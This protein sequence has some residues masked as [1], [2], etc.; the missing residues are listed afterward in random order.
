V[1]ARVHVW[2]ARTIAA[3][4]RRGPGRAIDALEGR[5][6]LARRYNAAMRS[7][8]IGAGGV[9]GVIAQ[10]LAE[11]GC[12]VRV[13]ARGAHGD[14]IARRGLVVRSPAGERRAALHVLSAEHV[15]DHSV[16]VAFVCVKWP[17]LPSALAELARV[18]VPDGVVVPLL[19]GLDAEDLT[20]QYVGAQRTIAGVAYMSAGIAEPGVIYEHGHSKLGF[21]AYRPGQER[22]V[23]ELVAMACDA[24]L[25]A[26]AHE[27]AAAMLWSKMVWNA[28]FNAICA[29]AN[30]NAGAVVVQDADLVK[31]AMR[32]VIAVARAHGVAL[33]DLL[34]DGMLHVT[35]SEFPDTVPSMLQDVRRGRPTE[36]DILAGRVAELG[37]ARAVPTPVLSTLASLVRMRTAEP[38]RA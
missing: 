4:L 32:E 25:A 28:P 12:D 20:A 15:A 29:L 16:D 6:G 27:D 36:I 18:L 22:S 5:R 7:L 8:V 26:Q 17:E 13:V 34:V 21:A 37:A 23:A 24:G 14:A 31:Q 10:R 2:D 33:P 30:L 35:R 38:T 3:Q 1:G 19:N 9:G 11:H